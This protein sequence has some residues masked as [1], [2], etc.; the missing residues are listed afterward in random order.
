MAAEGRE[1]VG[2]FVDARFVDADFTGATFR[3]CDLR[4]L[5]VIDSLLVDV[6]I[7]G[8]VDHLVVNGVDVTAFV[9]T[10][11]ERRHP[12]RAQLREMHTAA[13]HRAMWDTIER[14][15]SETTIRVRRL[16]ESFRQERGR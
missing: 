15:W 14:L 8:I 3:S 13:E 2:T 1:E 6:E 10:E 5:K 11:L 7:S 4:R 12:E 16:P 9:E